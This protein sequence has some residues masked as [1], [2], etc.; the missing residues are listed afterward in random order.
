MTTKEKLQEEALRKI[1][2]PIAWLQNDAEK[3]GL[4]LDGNWAIQMAGDSNYLRGIANDCLSQLAELKEEEPKQS[5]PTEEEIH[6]IIVEGLYEAFEMG[7]KQ[8]PMDADNSEYCKPYLDL[9][10]AKKMTVELI[11]KWKGE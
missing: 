4:R 10:K 11:N 9:D 3:R 6:K 8:S 1:A 2:N 5:I 7:L